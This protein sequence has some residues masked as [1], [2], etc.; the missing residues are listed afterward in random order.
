MK[1]LETVDYIMFTLIFLFALIGT[2]GI[3]FFHKTYAVDDEK[4][5]NTTMLM[6]I[7]KDDNIGLN[8]L[9]YAFAWMIAIFCWGIL[10]IL[11]T[12]FIIS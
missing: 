2:F 1:N 5:R 8:L 3:V 7:T 6:K 4:E 9:S 12:L 11:L 10:L